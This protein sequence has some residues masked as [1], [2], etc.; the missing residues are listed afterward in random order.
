[1]FCSFGERNINSTNYYKSFN[2]FIWMKTNLNL[3]R[4]HELVKPNL[5]FWFLQFLEL[6]R[7]SL[8]CSFYP[9]NTTFLDIGQKSWLFLIQAGR[10]FECSRFTLGFTLGFALDSTL[11][12]IMGFT[13]ECT[14][15]FTLFIGCLYR[16]YSGIATEIA[17]E[18]F[19]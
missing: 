2:F 1:M 5:M 15:E 7:F 10:E 13:L 17:S 8:F 16:V 11:E 9:F 6:S 4:T 12:S 3:V 19:S 14:V 18:N